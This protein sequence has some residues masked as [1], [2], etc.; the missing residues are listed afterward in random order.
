MGT[1]IQG[2]LK[3]VISLGIKFSC[4]LIEKELLNTDMFVIGL[5]K[6]VILMAF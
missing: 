5:G 6:L 1:T 4:S 2:P 3:H